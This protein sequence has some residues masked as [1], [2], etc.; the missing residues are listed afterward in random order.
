MPIMLRPL[1]IIAAGLA[2]TAVVTLNPAPALAAQGFRF[3]N[4]DRCLTFGD[5]HTSARAGFRAWGNYC[6]SDSDGYL[7]KRT[8][9]S[10]LVVTYRGRT[11][12]L[13][14]PSGTRVRVRRCGSDPKREV[15]T[16]PVVGRLQ[17]SGQIVLIKWKN[18][19]DTCLWLDTSDSP[20]SGWIHAMPCEPGNGGQRWLIPDG[21]P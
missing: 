4:G 12:C 19:P 20:R 5:D 14:T 15:F 6:P 18:L 21:R 17:I 1:K 7:W 10:Q 13:S 9:R 8:K 11:H 2:V 16:F 3:K